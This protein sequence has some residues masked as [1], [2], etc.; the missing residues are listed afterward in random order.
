MP[1]E[2]ESRYDHRKIENKWY[3]IW[4][5]KGVFR[6]EFG[7]SEKSKSFKKKKSSKKT[8]SNRKSKTQKK[9]VEKQTSRDLKRQKPYCIVIP[10][11][12]ITGQLHVGHALNH[13]IQDVL[14]R[15][16]RKRGFKTL[17]LPGT[18]HA[19]I[20]TQNRVEKNL[21]TEGK[22]RLDLGRT[23]FEK[24]IWDWK[25][26]SGGLITEQMR[27][28]GDSVDWKRERFT[29]DRGLSRAVSKVFIEL[30]NKKLIFRGKRIINWCP[31]TSCTTALA[32][33]EVEHVEREGML[34]YIHYPF[35]DG[36]G[37]VTV[38]TT[39]PETM[40]GDTAV[41]VHPEDERFANFHGKKILL[42]LMKREIPMILDSSVEREFGTGA[43]KVTPAHDP[44]DFDIGLRHKLSA[45]RIMDDNARIN[46][47][48]GQYQGMDRFEARKKVVEDLKDQ[49]L[50]EKTETHKHAVGTC[51]RCNQDIEPIMSEQWFVKTK[52]LAKKAITAVKSGKIRFH[53][54][55]WEN[56][57]FDW[58]Y[59]IQDWCISRQLW[60]GH[61]I[62][63]YYC[64]ACGEIM[65][66]ET[67]P[68]KCSKCGK[69]KLRQD[70]DV[71]DTWFSSALWPFST[72]GWP[73]NTEDLETFYPT[74]VLVTSFDIIFFWV[75]RMIMFGQHFMKKPPFKDVYIHGLMRDEKGRKIS[76]S[77]GN[78]I[79]PV[80][81]IESYGADAYRFFLL[82]TL[83]E[84]KDSTYSERR[85]KGYQNFANKIWNSTRFVLMNLPD[86]FKP[87]SANLMKYKL[88][89]ADFWILTRLN[90]TISEME[91]TL[92]EY[93]FHLTTD[94]IYTFV[95][96]NYCDWYIEFIKPRMF[97][98]TSPD[99]TDAARQTAFYV[100]RAMLG[101]LHPFLPFVTEEIYS[102]L[103]A[104]EKADNIKE[105]LLVTSAWP[106]VKKLPKKAL[107]EAHTL[108][109][110][111]EII[112]RTR[113]IRAET[114]IPVDKKVNLIVRTNSQKLTE[115]LEMNMIAIQRLAR[116]ETI[117]VVTEYTPEKYDSV[118]TFSEGEI[119]LPLEGMLD[120]E[121]EVI[122]LKSEKSKLLS[123]SIGT[124]KK[125][126]NQGF[127]NNAPEDVV[128]K[129]KDKLS[130]IREKIATIDASLA[131]FE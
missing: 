12:N 111:Q 87:D 40:L 5:K 50:L 108:E 122:R 26:K 66:A 83:S 123:V 70:P 36:S 88:E 103:S 11:P 51:Y 27:K 62:P 13:T 107:I 43:V 79:D 131:R 90:N 71:L 30:F 65:A 112:S 85:L 124:E 47:N 129:E 16:A 96:N 106:E 52:P 39:R 3:N 55:R 1:Q 15:A 44:N 23:E 89:P 10:P 31:S 81:V 84:G 109:L 73:D 101:L 6:P 100:L 49:G 33:D 95:W 7:D 32:N 42:P 76:K 56:L 22:S 91:R 38:A 8:K 63:V 18:D 127:L 64:D 59:N 121:K 80:D 41:A 34:W 19:G 99:S 72:N 46:E 61:R 110:I 117:S 114:G 86:D 78:N 120:I 69:S 98:K 45:I 92:D 77:L 68:K 21:Q 54:K 119:Y 9:A 128:Q 116:A 24:M 74:S 60:W 14:I 115:R 67:K 58:M 104:F 82:A 17:W 29:L 113:V 118:E 126:S 93:K 4:E 75:A 25:K 102:Y 37:R 48:G 97:G 125:L 53:P 94:Q 2:L 20:A 35:S 105:K 130:E 57:Y 28:L